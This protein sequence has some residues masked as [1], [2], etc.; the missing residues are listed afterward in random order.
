MA[1]EAGHPACY[2][3]FLTGG[4]V[5]MGRIDM[6]LWSTMRLRRTL[7]AALLPAL[8]LPSAFISTQARAAA[9]PEAQINWS[10]DLAYAVEQLRLRHPDPFHDVTEA[11]F[12]ARATELADRTDGLSDWQAAIE[13]Q[14]LV[15]LLGEG[16]TGLGY[17]QPEFGVRGYPLRFQSFS[18]GLFVQAVRPG[19]ERLLGARLRAIGDVPV[20]E[21]ERRIRAILSAD[22][23]SGRR[24]QIPFMLS[25]NIVLHVL[26]ITPERDQAKYVL[27]RVDGVR[28]T[29]SLDS[30][31][32]AEVGEM[33]E[34]GLDIPR[35]E[36]WVRLA[37]GAS[38]P[39][40]LWLKRTVDLY[41]FEHL[42]DSR[43]L[44]VQINRFYNRGEFDFGTF[45]KSV[46]DA[47]DR[48]QPDR[49]VIDLRHNTGG[50]HID[51]PFVHEILKRPGLAERGRLFALIG[52]STFSAAQ[53][54]VNH[55]EEHTD[56]L[57]I[58]EET[59]QRPNMYGVVG[60]FELPSSGLRLSHSRYF[61][62]GVDPADFRQATAPHIPV[63]Y[64]VSDHASGRDPA[65]EAAIAYRPV[66]LPHLVSE[67]RS[68]YEADGITAALAVYERLAPRFAEQGVSTEPLL[69]WVG[70]GLVRDGRTED[71]IRIFTANVE[72]NPESTN[73]GDALAEA[74]F[75]V[76][77]TD[78]AIAAAHAALALNPAN[79]DAQRV[80]RRAAATSA[81][82]SP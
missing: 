34:P 70:N 49:L 62:Q 26:G 14:R 7:H 1:V 77:R 31:P 32:V 33:L 74:L 78:E 13:I 6:A 25:V 38:H 3:P 2:Y 75:A 30:L 5:P 45:T 21:V 58:G 72:A 47:Y 52:R 66:E 54:F 48:H 42:A 63:D 71:A 15:A 68:A 10:S 9:A 8:L 69:S 56:A 41:W 81:S 80:L 36:G 65:L 61:I 40:A 60:R 55:L 37:D 20:E 18:D 12:M 82:E 23:D 57:F 67:V 76:G 64:T 46:F 43:T 22:N 24:R 4:A 39:G 17:L 59:A 29:V 28:E 51:L 79:S 73:A 53:T 27:E 44:Y 35:G 16:H 50:D 11:E 19:Q